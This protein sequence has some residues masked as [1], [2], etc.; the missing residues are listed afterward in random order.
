MQCRGRVSIVWGVKKNGRTESAPLMNGI[1]LMYL[2]NIGDY[3]TKYSLGIL[4]YCFQ[5]LVF[6]KK[7]PLFPQSIGIDME[8]KSLENSFWW[9]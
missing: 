4:V 8:V 3:L 1:G 2:A 9:T 7:N 5:Y 6:K